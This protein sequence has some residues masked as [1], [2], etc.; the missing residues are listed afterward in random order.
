MFQLPGMAFPP[1][2]FMRLQALHKHWLQ[3]LRSLEGKDDSTINDIKKTVIERWGGVE[4]VD[5]VFK[6]LHV[7]RMAFI[8]YCL[9]NPILIQLL[10]KISSPHHPSRLCIYLLSYGYHLPAPQ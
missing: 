3:F 2:F 8:L 4:I 6:D 9:A 7:F 1:L 10:A 5:A